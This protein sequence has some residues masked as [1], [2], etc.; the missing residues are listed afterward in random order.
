MVQ[1]NDNGCIATIELTALTRDY[2]MA[3]VLLCYVK[4]SKWL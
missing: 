1:Y 4:I 2:L 3:R